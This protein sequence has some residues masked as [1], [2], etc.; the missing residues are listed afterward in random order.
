MT[1]LR[2]SYYDIKLTDEARA[3]LK[4]SGPSNN[5][6]KK[7][8]LSNEEKDMPTS[9]EA[10]WLA[11]AVL[12]KQGFNFIPYITLKQKTPVKT[13]SKAKQASLVDGIM[14]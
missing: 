2:V 9:E 14:R 6:L 13:M 10:R 11:G 1:K 3:A 8:L 4:R 12:F 5:R 7:I